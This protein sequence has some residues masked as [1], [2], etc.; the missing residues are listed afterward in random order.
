MRVVA[1]DD[2]KQLQ[3]IAFCLMTLLLVVLLSSKR[4]KAKLLQQIQNLPTEKQNKRNIIE[5]ILLD[6][7]LTHAADS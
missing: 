7:S 3:T 6:L 2:T 4:S 1:D 5:D